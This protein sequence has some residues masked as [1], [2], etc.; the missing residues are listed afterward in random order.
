[1]QPFR[2]LKTLLALSCVVLICAAEGQTTTAKKPL[3]EEAASP[4]AEHK[5]G[6]VVAKPVSKSGTP[7]KSQSRSKSQVS[8]KNSKRRVS[9]PAK[10]RGQQGIDSDRA[11]EIQQALIRQKYLEGEATGVWDTRTRAAMVRFQSDNGWQTKVVPDSRALIKLG[12]GPKHANLINPEGAAG[13]GLLPEGTRALR[14]GGSPPD[15]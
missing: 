15:E 5:H 1:L 3:D 7:P 10:R 14:P 11:R 2:N 13:A 9:T 12:L 4:K 6:E 8:S